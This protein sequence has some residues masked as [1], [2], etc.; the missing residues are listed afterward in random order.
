MDKVLKIMRHLISL[1]EQSKKDILE[2]L[3]L[4]QKLKAK[5]EAGELTNYLSNKTLLMLFQKT[6]TRTRLSFEA[7]MTELGG[8]AIFLDARTSQ[9][10]L[11]DFGDEIRA[12]MRFGAILMFRALKAADVE[13]AASY[14]LIPVIDGC[15]EKYHPAQALGDI[16]TMMEHSHGLSNIK[17][18]V[19]LGI[20]N[21]VSN[22]LMLACAKLGILFTIIAP[23]IDKAS[24]DVELNKQAGAAGI[25][26]R[27]LDIAE[28][29]RGADY[30]HTDTWV[31]MEFFEGGKIK[32]EFSAE[33]ERRKK[34]FLPYQLNA[35]LINT[36]APSAKIMHC[37][38]C[39]I[40]YEISR[41]AVDHKN[42]IIFDQ[43]ENRMHIQKAILM[44]LL[45][46]KVE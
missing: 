31:N 4:A 43:A 23:E 13:R 12:I 19:W 32:P 46:K 21:N 41:D 39:H 27:T 18:V 36:Y 44:W 33:Y 30:V 8:H 25:V 28:G 6:S 29:L 15:S 26:K 34:V 37:M 10:A 3:D 16:L 40:G 35:K 45:E 5:R 24:I 2:I 14:N 1:K 17:K 20:E 22:T 42:S 7:A 11:T 9:L 38:P